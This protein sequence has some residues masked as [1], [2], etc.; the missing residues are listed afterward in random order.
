[1]Y[2]ASKSTK[3][4]IVEDAINIQKLLSFFLRHHGFEVLG[5]S[6]G[7][8]AMRVIPEFAPHLIVLDI[9][10]KPVSGW[11]VLHWLR[12]NRLIPQIPVLVI[13]ALVDLTEQMHGLEEGAFDYITKPAQPSVIVERVDLLLSLSSEQRLMLQHKRIDEQRK[14]LKRVYSVQTDEFV[15]EAMPSGFGFCTDE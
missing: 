15:Y 3:I 14:V 6:D 4:L 11:D 8:E 12:T 5:V 7:R 10:M 9:L 1:I 2:D 13:S